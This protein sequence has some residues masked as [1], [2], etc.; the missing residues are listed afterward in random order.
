MTERVLYEQRDFPIFQNRMYDSASEARACPRGDIRLVQDP[1]SGLVHNAAFQPDLMQYDRHYQNEQAVSGVFQRH[2]EQVTGIVER[3]L[4]RQGIIEVGCGKGYFLEQ[5]LSAGIDVRGFDPA[6]EGDNPRI[7]RR[8]FDPAVGLTGQGLVLRHVLEHLQSPFDFLAQLRTANGGSGLIYIEVPCLDWILD[9]RAWFDIFYEHVNYFRLV[10]F[11]RLFADVRAKGHLFGGQYLYVVAE[12]ASLRQPLANDDDQLRFPA[13]FLST[14]IGSRQQ[15]A[16]SRQ[17]VA[18]WGGAS[19]GVIFS[20]LRER[21]GQPVDIVI[22]VNPAKQNRYLPATGL[23]VYSPEE[24][25]AK[26]P[27][28]SP[29]YIMNS[30]Y[31]EEI[32]AMSGY[33]YHYIEVEYD[34]V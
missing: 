16:G 2:L 13:D 24:A 21:L 5:L 10:D 33:R 26:L 34:E 14:L 28:G 31:A 6:Y 23:R 32:K 25:L 20:L 17:Q 8:P 18:V 19:K 1:A 4:G 7:D 30:N 9:H 11:E 22:D 27:D 15:A 29:L 12:L 3:Y